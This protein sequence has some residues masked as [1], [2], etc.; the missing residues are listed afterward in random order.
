MKGRNNMSALY[1]LP[2]AFLQQN[3]SLSR[4]HL[5]AI[6]DLAATDC[7]RRTVLYVLDWENS[8]TYCI[9]K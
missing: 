2:L 4:C 5:L 9:T 1:I 3:S 7:I 8:R 6:C